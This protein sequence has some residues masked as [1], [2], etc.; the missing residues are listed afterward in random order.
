MFSLT[1]KNSFHN[2]KQHLFILK[3]QLP[4]GD[5]LWPAWWLTGTDGGEQ[6]TLNTKWP[7]NGEIDIIE[8][9][10]APE[11]FMSRVS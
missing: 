4:F 6:S 2:N 7:T 8:L 1:S 5:S 3:A 9:V 11:K 10:N